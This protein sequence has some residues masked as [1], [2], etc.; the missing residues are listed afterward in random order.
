MSHMYVQCSS[1]RVSCIYASHFLWDSN[2]RCDCLRLGI[3][4]AKVDDDDDDGEVV[5]MVV[6]D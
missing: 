2:Q 1:T 3:V 5:V 4:S 6:K